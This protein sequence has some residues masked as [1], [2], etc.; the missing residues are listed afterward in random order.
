M[1]RFTTAVLALLC[2]NCFSQQYSKSWRDLNYAGDS[3][4]YHRLD[5]Y[6][7]VKE[8][9]VY[10]VVIS[11]YGSAWM[12]NNMKGSDLG[13]FG[14]ALLDAG[15]AV[16]TPN[17][18]SS[19]DA[20]FPAQ[21]HDIKAV[22]RFI[23]ANAATYQLDTSFIGINGFS[24]GGH[25]S[26]LAGTSGSVGQHTVGATTFDLEGSLGPDTTF[27]SA[28]HAVVDWSGPTDLLVLDSCRNTPL[29]DGAN[30]PESLL[31]GGSVQDN[32]DKAT[33]ADPITYID[34]NDPPFLILHGDADQTVPSCQ[35]TL[36]YEALQA[37]NVQ[38]QL[39]LI[40]NAQHGTNMFL[41]K[42][43]GMMIEFL[44]TISG[45]TA[46]DVNEGGTAP[47]YRIGS[48]YPNPFNPSTTIEYSL[49]ADSKIEIQILDSLGRLVRTLFNGPSGSGTH[50]LTWD[51]RDDSGHPLSSGLYYYQITSAAFTSANKMLLLK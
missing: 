18:R 26:A 42:Y 41:D 47:E 5:I 28:V 43:Y 20:K 36:L 6:L 9:P 27:S 14:R 37:A 39:V 35:S 15:Y 16:V 38:S 17:H 2:V 12:S 19:M 4:Q 24:S 51:G 21:I 1:K 32:R 11:I 8:K 22:V 31:I 13:T 40:P 29:N 46:V 48:N 50:R 10:P 34:A 45:I 7:P 33:L 23:R 44:G 3:F 30:S 25:L 49:K